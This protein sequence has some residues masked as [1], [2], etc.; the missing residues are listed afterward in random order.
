MIFIGSL[1]HRYYIIYK[2]KLKKEPKLWLHHS[3]TS[4]TLISATMMLLIKTSPLRHKN[5][6]TSILRMP[7]L[8]ALK[9]LGKILW[10]QCPDPRKP[11]QAHS[12]AA[13]NA[14]SIKNTL[15]PVIKKFRISWNPSQLAQK[16]LKK[17]H[18]NIKSSK[19]NLRDSIQL[20]KS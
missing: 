3:S 11:V 6:P 7:I 20:N 18:L 10:A 13:S 8:S 15:K 14:T 9:P 17:N 5:T 12:K 1:L 4:P 19:P 2:T 16:K